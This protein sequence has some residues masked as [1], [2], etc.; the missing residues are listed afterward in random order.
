MMY[1]LS[2]EDFAHAVDL[3]VIKQRMH[4]DLETTRTWEDFHQKLLEHN[5]YCVW[6][7]SKKN[8][9]VVMHIIP[10][11]QGTEVCFTI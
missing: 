9:A 2:D 7:E 11:R 6:T 4:I 3:E 1:I 8:H 10:H 5:P